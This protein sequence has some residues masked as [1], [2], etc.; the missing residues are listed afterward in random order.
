VS[1]RGTSGALAHRQRFVGRPAGGPADRA[2]LRVFEAL[3][4]SALRFAPLSARLVGQEHGRTAVSLPFRIDG[5]IDR[6]AIRAK[7]HKVLPDD[8]RWKK[9][10]QTVSD[11]VR[12]DVNEVALTAL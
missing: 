7:P 12:P 3:T 6:K 1:R 10:K 8:G 5:E 9:L 4:L 2:H 11:D